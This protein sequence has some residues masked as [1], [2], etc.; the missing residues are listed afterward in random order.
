MSG[1]Q[2]SVMHVAGDEAQPFAQ[3][4]GFDVFL[5]VRSHGGEVVARPGQVR[6]SQGDAD[7]HRP[8]GRPDVDE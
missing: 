4:E 8:L 1:R 6:V 5:E 7:G 2:W 3:C